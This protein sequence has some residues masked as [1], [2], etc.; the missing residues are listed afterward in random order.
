M[1]AAQITLTPLPLVSPFSGKGYI[2]LRSTHC[3][4][5]PRAPLRKEASDPWAVVRVPGPGSLFLR[6][7]FPRAAPIPRRSFLVRHLV[8][9]VLIF[10]AR[11]I[12]PGHDKPQKMTKPHVICCF[13]PGALWRNPLPWEGWFLCTGTPQPSTQFLATR[14]NSPLHQCPT[15]RSAS[16]SPSL[17]QSPERT[18][19]GTERVC[20][21][22]TWLPLPTW[23]LL[24]QLGLQG[25]G[26]K[27]QV[28]SLT[29]STW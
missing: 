23:A 27:V 14:C 24:F 12:I 22:Y 25:E 3:W 18:L 20:W 11:N 9:P 4:A 17:E 16:D 6:P 1:G 2:D 21:T 5:F 10:G 7:L 15:S 8:D 13:A 19:K 26:L 29:L 28:W